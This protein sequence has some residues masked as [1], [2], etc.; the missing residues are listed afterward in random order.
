MKLTLV[1]ALSAVVVLMSHVEAA[2]RHRHLLDTSTNRQ[3]TDV[4]SVCNGGSVF[5]CIDDS[6][7][8]TELSSDGT[9]PNAR[10]VCTTGQVYCCSGGSGKPPITSSGGAGGAGGAGGTGAGGIGGLGGAGGVITTGALISADCLQIPENILA[11]LI[12]SLV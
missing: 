11:G 1:I 4:H 10:A 6:C 3:D 7:E 12:A 8:V 2:G 9:N 5:C